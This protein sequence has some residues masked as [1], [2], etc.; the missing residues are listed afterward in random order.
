MTPSWTPA[1]S[2]AAIA[3]SQSARV[4]A[5]GFSTMTW[6]PFAAAAS[7]ASGVHGVWRA[8]RDRL[9]AGLAHHRRDVGERRD[10]VAGRE[11]VG[12]RLRPIADRDEVRG[13]EGGE[14]VGVGRPT[15][16]HP[17]SAVRNRIRRHHRA[18]AVGLSV[19]SP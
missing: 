11:R 4:A 5:S 17:M 1:A 6:A 15:L 18:G 2:H 16:P 7:I 13:G 3:R 8:H 9:D 10:A 14:R 12:A 19:A